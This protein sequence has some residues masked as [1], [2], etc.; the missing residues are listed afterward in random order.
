VLAEDAQ[1]DVADQGLLGAAV[2]AAG[3]LDGGDP[4][5]Q[6]ADLGIAQLG[7]AQPGG[8]QP[9]LGVADQCLVDRAA[10]PQVAV[11]EQLGWLPSG[12]HV[13]FWVAVQIDQAG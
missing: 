3:S 6:R 9:V 10:A 5:D 4:A 11:G 1:V 8:Q 7:V 12:K 13:E 2:A